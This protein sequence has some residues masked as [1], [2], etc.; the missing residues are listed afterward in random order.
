MQLE[1][2][3]AIVRRFLTEVAAGADLAV[4]PEL[5]A[6]DVVDHAAM[7]LGLPPGI[8]SLRTHI[9][10]VNTSLSDFVVT[11]SDMVAEGDRVVAFWT[12]VGKHVG[13]LF[14]VAPTGEQISVNAISTVTVKDGRITEYRVM[15]DAT[16]LVRNGTPA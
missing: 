3:K 5:V 14:G 11:V 2:N 12:G 1:A 6:D 13:P 16:A 7:A 4:L 8:E 10:F 15:A 9:S